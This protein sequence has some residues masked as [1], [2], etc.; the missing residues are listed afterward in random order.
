MESGQVEGDGIAII[1]SD[2]Y[3]SLKVAKGLG[4][5]IRG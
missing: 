5:G 2:I 3:G 1:I 4:K